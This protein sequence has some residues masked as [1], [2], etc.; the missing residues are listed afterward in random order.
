M[1]YWT[2][3]FSKELFSFYWIQHLLWKKQRSTK[4]LAF[5]GLTL[6]FAINQ[7][8]LRSI[9]VLWILIRTRE[10]VGR[11]SRVRGLN[12]SATGPDPPFQFRFNCLDTNKMSRFLIYWVSGKLVKF[13]LIFMKIDLLE[14]NNWNN[15]FITSLKKFD[16]QM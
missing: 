7:W 4:V 9:Y 15:V 12:H 10:I 16:W 1:K 2:L 8:T 11:R 3:I 5:K 14:K 6:N 13:K